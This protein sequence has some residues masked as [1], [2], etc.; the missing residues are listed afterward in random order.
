MEGTK[1]FLEAAGFTIQELPFNDATDKFWV[2]KSTVP[3]LE[4]MYYA[5]VMTPF[6]LI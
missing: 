6:M 3:L 2:S 5:L 4:I 1:E